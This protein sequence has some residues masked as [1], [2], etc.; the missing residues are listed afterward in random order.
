MKY[1]AHQHVCTIDLHRGGYNNNTHSSPSS[2]RSLK[3]RWSWSC[4]PEQRKRRSFQSPPWWPFWLKVFWGLLLKCWRAKQR[5]ER[6]QRVFCLLV[7]G[8]ILRA[9]S[10]CVRGLLQTEAATYLICWWRVMWRRRGQSLGIGKTAFPSR[11]FEWPSWEREERGE[12]S[13]SFSRVGV[14]PMVLLLLLAGKRWIAHLFT[15]EKEARERRGREGEGG[16]SIHPHES[17]R[18]KGKD[19]KFI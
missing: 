18:R 11:N 16:L 7:T 14:F 4:G 17:C 12:K 5:L 8:W 10:W 13:K 15:K 2:G 19:F 9:M 3:S 1:K 6:K